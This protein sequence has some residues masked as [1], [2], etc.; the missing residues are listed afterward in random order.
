MQRSDRGDGARAGSATKPTTHC[1]GRGLAHPSRDLR[2]RAVRLSND[3]H[4]PASK[5]LAAHDLHALPAPR[6][7]SVVDRRVGTLVSGSMGRFPPARAR[8]PWPSGSRRR[9][10][11]RR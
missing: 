2:Q 4:A 5:L 9:W 11:A 8:R 3:E 6:M 7:E 10:A 1:G